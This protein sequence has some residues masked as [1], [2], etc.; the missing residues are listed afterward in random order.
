M[1]L[2]YD[3]REEKQRTV[4]CLKVDSGE[5]EEVWSRT[6][7][8][9]AQFGYGSGMDTA[10]L[11]SLDGASVMVISRREKVPVVF[12]SATGETSATWA[13]RLTGP[14]A[15]HPSRP[16]LATAL[17]EGDGVVLA[18]W[19]T[20]EALASIPEVRSPKAL[21]WSPDGAKLAVSSADG[22]A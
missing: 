5:T 6:M 7:P 1:V 22:T 16:I 21:A 17:A 10:V 13:T 14:H 15:V 11:W 12:D 8:V 2:T 20:G 3:D 19:R 9:G 18:D 4:V